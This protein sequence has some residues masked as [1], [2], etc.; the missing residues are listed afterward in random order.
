[1]N[2]MSIILDYS[3]SDPSGS[4]RLLFEC[5]IHGLQGILHW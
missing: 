2:E 1:M 3:R 4:R 5:A